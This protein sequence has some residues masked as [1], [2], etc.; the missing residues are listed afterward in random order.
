[1]L[2]SPSAGLDVANFAL[3]LAVQLVAHN[4]H[5]EV[6]RSKGPGI[7]QPPRQGFEGGPFGDVIYEQT[8]ARPSVV[9][10]RHRP[11]PFLACRVPQLLAYECFSSSVAKSKEAYLTHLHLDILVAN[12]EDSRGELDANRMCRIFF[13]LIVNEMMEQA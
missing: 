6:G 1:M 10:S 4:N 5:N 11:K 8:G 12:F 9:A 2:S 7:S 13:V 3:F